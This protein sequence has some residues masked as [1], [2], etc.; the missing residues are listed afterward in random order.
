MVVVLGNVGAKVRE[1]KVYGNRHLQSQFIKSLRRK[2]NYNHQ[3]PPLLS[4]L[5]RVHSVYRTVLHCPVP[6]SLELSP[7]RRKEKL[8]SSYFLPL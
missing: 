3:D 1:V 5:G 2:K 4:L 7:V 6:T 8:S